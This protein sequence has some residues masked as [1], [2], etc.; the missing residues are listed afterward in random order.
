VR[1]NE[2]LSRAEDLRR[3]RTPYV[4]A[5]V[6][7]AQRP[8]SAKAGDCA[9][10]LADGTLDGFIGGDCAEST[11]RL[12]GLRILQTGASTLLRITPSPEPL[13]QEE[14]G[15][16]VVNNPCLSGGSLEI[17]LEAMLPAPL[18]CV[19]GDSPVARALA[20]IG[21]AAGYEMSTH[22]IDQAA[23][24]PPDVSAVVV[25][26]HGHGEE[27]VLEAA[28]RAG[29]PYIALVASRKRGDAVLANVESSRDRIHTPAGLDIGA[30]TAS[31]VAI[32]ILAELI[33]HTPRTA[34]HPTSAAAV[35]PA[36]AAPIAATTAVAPG[37]AVTAPPVATPAA[38]AERLG[39]GGRATPPGGQPGRFG[40]PGG[41]MES[42]ARRVLPM[43]PTEIAI[44]PVCHMEV[45]ITPAA[46]RAEHAAK[47]YYFCA[48]GCKASFVKN[49]NAY[50]PSHD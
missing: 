41:L 25:A 48:S 29:V 1:R 40:G 32:S 7:R 2:L 28:L 43:A 17:F 36:A 15:L 35:A 37:A 47:S 45:T 46:L 23:A 13:P 10:V 6:V 20:A 27:H 24:L 34:A 44:D 31:E 38:L 4:L 33:A 16:V 19:Y 11:V 8:T 5:T 26:S 39:A 50:L 42:A 49:P 14:E 3:A 21:S 22:P 30:R 12:Q 9:L 18:I